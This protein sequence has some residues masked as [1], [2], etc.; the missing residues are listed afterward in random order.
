[1]LL[2][3]YEVL[4]MS[5]LLQILKERGFLGFVDDEDFFN[6]ISKKAATFYIGYDP[7]GKS[8]HAGN[9]LTLMGLVHIQKAGHR[10][11][12][13]VG[14]GTGL[15]GDPSGKSEER[16]LLDEDRII[17]NQEAITNQISSFLDKNCGEGVAVIVNNIDWIGKLSFVDFLRGVGKNFRVNEMVQKE[18]VKKRMESR[19]GISLTEFCYQTLQAYDFVELNKRYDCSFQ[20][21]GMDQWGNIAAGIDLV[22]RLRGK[23]VHGLCFPLMTKADGSKF[24]KTESGAIWLDPELTSPFNFYQFW[25][26][27]DDRD[28]VKYLKLFTFLPLE[29]IENLEDVLEESPEKREPHKVLAFEVTSIVHG[30]E[31]AEKAKAASELIYSDSLKGATDQQITTIFSDVPSTSISKERLGN[32]ITLVDVLS[33]CGLCKSKGDARRQI[34]GG[35]IYLN[36][37]RCQEIEKVL[38]LDDLASENFMVIR[39]GKKN[40]HL[41]RIH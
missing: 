12:A 15:I 41:I 6:A 22:R 11:V 24:G 31:E 33:E 17:S 5:D 35:G 40:H 4:L 2:N 8:L 9:L 32:G 39:R 14:G 23:K 21:G 16:A 36:D 20:A 13:L 26:R 34:K 10:P 7:S 30:Q 25:V 3:F 28:V 19:E 38:F 18:S 1:M 29:K 37:R 27:T